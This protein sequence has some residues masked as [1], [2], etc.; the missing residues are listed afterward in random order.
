VTIK[1]RLFFQEDALRRQEIRGDEGCPGWGVRVAM[2]QHPG[3]ALY[4]NTEDREHNGAGS[5]AY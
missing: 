1:L 5:D 4:P 3:T 2:L